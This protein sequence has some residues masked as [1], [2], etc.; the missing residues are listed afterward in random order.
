MAGRNAKGYTAYENYV[1]FKNSFT[2]FIAGLNPY[3][4][5]PAEQWDL[6]KYSPAFA[7]CMAPFAA[8]PDWAGLP[9]WNLLNALGLLAA[10]WSVV[11]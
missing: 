9:I 8:L 10:I 1:I 6:Y 7:L 3:A 5:F 4:N 11:T 2:H